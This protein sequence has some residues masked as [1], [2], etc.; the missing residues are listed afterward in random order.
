MDLEYKNAKEYWKLLKD[1]QN[2]NSSNPLYAQ[3]FKDYFKSINDPDTPHFQADEDILQFNDRLL[4]SEVQIMFAELDEQIFE[5][6]IVN[7]IKKSHSGKSGGPD[8]L[9]NSFSLMELVFSQSIYQYY[10]MLYRTLV[11]FLLAGLMAI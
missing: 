8:R 5:Q 2:V 7:V 3:K 9:L 1:Y 11:I 10:L 4:N 6:E